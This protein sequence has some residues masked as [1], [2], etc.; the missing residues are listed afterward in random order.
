MR[1]VRR[2]AGANPEISIRTKAR[3]TSGVTPTAGPWKSRDDIRSIGEQREIGRQPP[4]HH[5]I[6]IRA[7]ET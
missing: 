5:P 1:T 2:V 6:V 4:T 7:T 3:A